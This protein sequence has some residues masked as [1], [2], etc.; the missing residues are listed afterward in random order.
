MKELVEMF[1]S[2]YT[3]NYENN[4]EISPEINGIVGT[5]DNTSDILLEFSDF[6][7]FDMYG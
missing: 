4:N 2:T 5:E 1:E 6:D 7:D 3:E